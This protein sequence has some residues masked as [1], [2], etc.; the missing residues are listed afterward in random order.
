MKIIGLFGASSAFGM[1]LGSLLKTKKKV[2]PMNTILHKADSRGK[3]FHGWLE[4]YHTFSFANYY[5]PERMHFGALRVINDDVIAPSMGFG[6]HPHRDMEIISVPIS[7]SLRHKDTLGNEYAIKKG[8]IQ[9]MSA[10]H[11]IYHSEYNNSDKEEAN[12]LQIWVLPKKLGIDPSYSQKEFKEAERKNKFQ[13]VVSPDG[14]DNSASINQDAFFSL[15]NVEKGTQ[16]EYKKYLDKNGV[17][18]FV[19]DGSLK[20]GDTLLEKRDGIGIEA[21]DSIT[22]EALE[23][24]ELLLMEVPMLG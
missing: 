12:F 24:V 23:D 22:L 16:I 5:N 8:E 7:G 1:G 18:L 17:Y 3:A 9:T 13:L 11:G 15:S 2:N 19:I 21:V 4:S 6:T 20:V 14:R 10:G